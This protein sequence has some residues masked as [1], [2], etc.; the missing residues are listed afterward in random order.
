MP[1]TLKVTVLEDAFWIHPR[2]HINKNM[3]PRERE[4]NL[5]VELSCHSADAWPELVEGVRALGSLPHVSSAAIR[6]R[7]ND[8]P[9]QCHFSAFYTPP[10]PLS[11]VHIVPDEDEGDYLNEVYGCW[12]ALKPGAIVQVSS[13]VRRTV[14]DTSR[15]ALARCA[16]CKVDDESD[17]FIPIA[18]RITFTFR[19][20]GCPG[21]K[22]ASLYA[23]VVRLTR[24][25]PDTPATRE[26]RQDLHRLEKKAETWK[27]TL[28]H[29]VNA[30][31]RADGKKRMERYARE[32]RE[33]KERLEYM[34]NLHVQPLWKTVRSAVKIAPRL[35]SAYDA[36]MEKSYAPG[37]PGY[38]RVRSRTDVGQA[39]RALIK[40]PRPA[41]RYRPHG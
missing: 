5:F 12:W 41:M 21:G 17:K 39:R 14:L 9:R 32:I 40:P 10:L 25:L 6:M 13:L 27:A 8:E 19:P 20:D 7:V 38:K 22:S 31:M 26:L 35:K 34:T 29:P 3:I 23:S 11:D 36:A 2:R 1:D 16:V 4:K 30:T 33:A 28:Q 18:G 24:S 15:A 37:G